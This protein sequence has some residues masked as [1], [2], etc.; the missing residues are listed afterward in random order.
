MENTP[1]FTEPLVERAKTGCD[2]AMGELWKEYEPV[3]KRLARKYLSNH[4]DIDS[5]VAKA[6]HRLLTALAKWNGSGAFNSWARTLLHRAICSW[7]KE[8]PV[9][10]KPFAPIDDYDE[11]SSERPAD[12]L[13]M[14]LLMTWVDEL[15][16]SQRNAFTQVA[17]NGLSNKEAAELL[18]ISEGTVKS[19]L[20]DARKVL[21]RKCIAAG[22]K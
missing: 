1:K 17:V 10:N 6:M 2:R 11:P 16:T 20:F 22:V 8:T 3:A 13:L 19:N 18:G 12:F 14:E 15:N 9:I 7:I 21:K 4:D 5:A